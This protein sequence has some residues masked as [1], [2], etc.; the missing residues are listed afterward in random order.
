MH[1]TVGAFFIAFDMFDLPVA[2][3]ASSARFLSVFYQR[4]LIKYVQPALCIPVAKIVGR[5]PLWFCQSVMGGFSI[6]L[7]NKHDIT[8][9]LNAIVNVIPEVTMNFTSECILIKG[10]DSTHVSLIVVNMDLKKLASKI[11]W[12]GYPKC[13][14]SFNAS[15]FLTL[16][17][18][19]PSDKAVI[20]K[21]DDDKTPDKLDILVEHEGGGSS[22]GSDSGS[23]RKREEAYKQKMELKLMNLDIEDLNPTPSSTWVKTTIHATQWKDAVSR[24]AKFSE[25]ILFDANKDRLIYS[26]A[27]DTKGSIDVKL[28]HGQDVDIDTSSDEEHVILKFSLMH[29]NKICSKI[30]VRP[31]DNMQIC[32]E[33]D[34]PCAFHYYTGDKDD[35]NT[36][37]YYYLAP[38]LDD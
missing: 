26:C 27:N 16:L 32:L 35:P 13:D 37:L 24:C 19:I 36:S 22:S 34:S 31:D 4:F 29:I 2:L 30:T 10:L 21:H 25:M 5:A 12:S 11:E 38:K 20:L 17:G 3:K 6:A 9:T 7:H 8:W 33:K 15:D 18:F 23:K 14:I 1:L 28:D